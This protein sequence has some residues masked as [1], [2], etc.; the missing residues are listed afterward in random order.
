MNYSFVR[1]FLL[2]QQAGKHCCRTCKEKKKK[3]VE[4]PRGEVLCPACKEE[5]RRKHACAICGKPT[6]K[7]EAS[8]EGYDLFCTAHWLAYCRK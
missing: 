6:M 7:K 3:K 1:T 4:I 5:A 2:S 8:E